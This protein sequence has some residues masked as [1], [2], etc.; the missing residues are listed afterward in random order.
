MLR[1]QPTGRPSTPERTVWLTRT[2]SPAIGP[3]SLAEFL[4]ALNTADFVVSTM[5]VKR[6]YNAGRFLP[7]ADFALES[8]EHSRTYGQTMA[9]SVRIRQARGT[10]L[11]QGLTVHITKSVCPAPTTLAKLVTSAGGTVTADVPE[12]TDELEVDDA[13]GRPKVVVISC[14]KDAAEWQHL[15]DGRLPAVHIYNAEFIIC[16]CLTQTLDFTEK[17]KCGGLT[18]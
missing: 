6:S 8:A 12:S 3:R 2:R 15:A 16:G 7:E 1:D 11:M 9:D 4:L 18:E 10:P 17:Y 5:W 13:L 14:P